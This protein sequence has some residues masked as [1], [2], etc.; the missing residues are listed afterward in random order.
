[1]SGFVTDFRSINCVTN[2]LALHVEVAVDPSAPLIQKSLASNHISAGILILRQVENHWPNVPMSLKLFEWV[3]EQ[4]GLQGWDKSREIEHSVTQPKSSQ[5]NPEIQ[6]QENVPELPHEFM[7]DLMEGNL[8]D[9]G[10]WF[11]DFVGFGFM[12]NLAMPYRDWDYELRHE[13]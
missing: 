6:M 11:D 12:D 10:G 5:D 9:S 4:N 2:V 8:R 13:Q 1:M 7:D 3:L